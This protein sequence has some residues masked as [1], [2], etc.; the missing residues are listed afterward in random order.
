MNAGQVVAK[1]TVAEV[2][3]QTQQNV[4]QR[5]IVQLRVRV[6]PELEK[7]RQSKLIGKSLEAKVTLSGKADLLA[8]VQRH[9]DTFRELLNVSQLQ[10]QVAEGDL[11]AE[12]TKADGLKCERCWHFET[13]VSQHPEHPTICGRCVEAVKQTN[14]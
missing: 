14:S 2:I 10:V 4:V 8:L 12:V 5:S 6:L 3:G 7:A 1:G 9:A 11:R 13:D